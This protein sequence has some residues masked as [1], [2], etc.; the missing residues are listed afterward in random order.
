MSVHGCGT[1]P[2]FWCPTCGIPNQTG[3]D[4][5]VCEDWWAKNPPPRHDDYAHSGGGQHHLDSA[6]E[7]A[8]NILIGAL[9]SLA[10]QALI[11]PVYGIHIG[12]GAHIGIVALFTVV[13]VVR[14]YV[15]RRVF[16][17]VSPYRWIKE[18]YL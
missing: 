6:L 2:Q 13:S 1:P 12:A 18:K 15:L 3:R 14:Q 17:G 5:S 9:V 4:C 11:F 10:A 7:V 8:T 16:N